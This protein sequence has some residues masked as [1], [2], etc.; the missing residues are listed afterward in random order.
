MFSCIAVFHATIDDI[1]AVSV[2]Y[3]VEAVENAYQ[4]SLKN[5]CR[6]LWIYFC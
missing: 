5:I 3:L 4:V 2:E 6:F 1:E